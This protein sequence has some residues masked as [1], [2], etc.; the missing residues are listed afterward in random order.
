MDRIRVREEVKGKEDIRE[1]RQTWKDANIQFLGQ[2]LKRK[3]SRH[4]KEVQ[5]VNGGFTCFTI[6]LI[7]KRKRNQCQKDKS[8]VLHVYGKG[9]EAS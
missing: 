4:T 8:P 5:N 1:E 2:I 9:T 3:E 6:Q 7:K